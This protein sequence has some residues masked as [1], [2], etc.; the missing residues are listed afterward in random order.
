[1]AGSLYFAGRSRPRGTPI[2]AVE[3]GDRVVMGVGAPNGCENGETPAGM[4]NHLAGVLLLRLDL[5]ACARAPAG[6]G[7][8]LAGRSGPG[9]RLALAGRKRRASPRGGALAPGLCRPA[10]GGEQA[11]A[12][13]DQPKVEARSVGLDR[14]GLAAAATEPAL[15]VA[16]SKPLDQQ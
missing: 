4:V 1:M 14:L 9:G 5:A 3:V 8:D 13:A 6:R 15:A 7:R 2:R 12:A 16:D 10:A 11:L